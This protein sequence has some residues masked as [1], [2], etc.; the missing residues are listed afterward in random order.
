MESLTKLLSSTTSRV[1]IVL[2]I[3][4]VGVGAWYA[5]SP[6]VLLKLSGNETVSKTTATFKTNSDW[7]VTYAYDCS[8]EG[9]TGNFGLVV[10]NPTTQRGDMRDKDIVVESSGGTTIKHY[11]ADAGRHY[12]IIISSCRWHITVQDQHRV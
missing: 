4:V 10:M 5:W 2:V 6:Q 9:N 8:S 12:L 11:T 1:I 7:N 3:I